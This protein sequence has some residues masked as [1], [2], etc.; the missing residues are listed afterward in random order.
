MLSRFYLPVAA[1]VQAFQIHAREIGVFAIQ[2]VPLADSACL[3]RE[4][5]ANELFAGIS[6]LF[7]GFARNLNFMLYRFGGLGFDLDLG[8]SL[9]LSLKIVRI[10][11]GHDYNVPVLVPSQLLYQFFLKMDKTK[12]FMLYL[13][14][15]DSNAGHCLSRVFCLIIHVI[16]IV[17]C[18][19]FR[20]LD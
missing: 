5:L 14:A 6:H 8:L 19:C 11:R 13:H 3:A 18:K 17:H 1:A 20:T 10:V 4:F 12:K 9:S 15:Y 16:V 2:I 7:F